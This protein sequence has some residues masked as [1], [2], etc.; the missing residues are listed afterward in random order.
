MSPTLPMYV[1]SRDPSGHFHRDRECGL[2]R[3]NR[4]NA[5]LMPEGTWADMRTRGIVATACYRC[6]PRWTPTQAEEAA[7]PVS[8]TEPTDRSAQL[9][10][11]PIESAQGDSRSYHI[12]GTN[13]TIHTTPYCNVVKLDQTLQSVSLS[14]LLQLHREWR[15]CQRCGSNWTVVGDDATS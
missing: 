5:A 3:R 10:T 9:N 11:L 1:Y 15:L 8:P 6:L 2:L 12:T 4:K 7:L 14:A 13:K